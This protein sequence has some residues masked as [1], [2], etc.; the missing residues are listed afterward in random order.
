MLTWDLSSR[1]YATEVQVRESISYF[2]NLLLYTS[3]TVSADTKSWSNQ[4]F[5]RLIR[6]PN[7]AKKFIFGVDSYSLLWCDIQT[8]HGSIP[9]I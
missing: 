6:K 2:L 4:K 1:T 9:L 3:K 7:A 8:T 5:S